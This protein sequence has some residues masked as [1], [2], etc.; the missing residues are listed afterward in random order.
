[1]NAA[2]F[3]QPYGPPQGAPH[4]QITRRP[5]TD[6]ERQLPANFYRFIQ[7]SLRGIAMLCLI[8]FVFNGYLLPVIVTDSVTYD[9]LSMV[10]TIFMV[11]MG[12][13]A[14]GM[15]VNAIA[16]RKRIGQ[17]MMDGT[18]VEVVAPAYRNSTMKNMQSWTVGP[19]SVLPTRGIEGLV[20][21][22][23]VTSVLC[24]PRMKAAIAINNCG[25]R[26]GARIMF[27]PNLE[28]MAVPTGFGPVVPVD[29]AP[30]PSPPTPPGEPV[31]PQAE[32]P[33]PPPDDEVAPAHHERK[34]GSHGHKKKSSSK[35]Q[36]H[37]SK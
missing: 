32:E 21:E 15:S 13:V 14:I 11:V 26:Q 16:V 17:A 1:M 10:L 37:R 30:M 9:A 23:A 19:V 34:S 31:A 5:M 33:P 25:L 27:P 12:A 6:S 36:N 8:L 24:V 20:Q 7:R 18:A 22:G 29:P 28:A 4:N 2:P 3:A 35:R